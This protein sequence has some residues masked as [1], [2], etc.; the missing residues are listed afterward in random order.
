MLKN[1]YERQSHTSLTSENKSAKL[2]AWCSGGRAIMASTS[3]CNPF[4]IEDGWEAFQF[5]FKK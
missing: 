3:N 2:F 1:K 5:A 4:A